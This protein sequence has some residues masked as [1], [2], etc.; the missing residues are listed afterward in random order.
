M[1]IIYSLILALG[2]I[3]LSYLFLAGIVSAQEPSPEIPEGYILIEGDILVPDPGDIGIQSVFTSTSLWPNGIVPY[4]FAANVTAISRT[5]IIS[6]MLEWQNAAN[7]NFRPRVTA[8]QFWVRIQN[9][10]GNNSPVGR[11]PLANQP[12]IINIFNWNSRFIMAHELAHTLGIWHE[13]SRPDRAPYVIINTANIISTQTHNFSIH[14][15]ADVYPLQVYGLSAVQ[16]YDF[17]S[18]MHYGQFDFSRNGK[19][20]ITIQPSIPN[21]T[22]LQSQIGQRTHLS[23]LDKLTMSF[24]YPQTNWRFVDKHHIGT[25]NGQFLTPYQQFPIGVTNTPSGG[26]LWLQPG[27][28]SA[29][30]T[31]TKPMTLQAPLSAVTLGN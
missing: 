19:P 11:Q 26:T 8:D 6:A 12:Q 5:N 23:K 31:Y 24:L 17:D 29:I 16:T 20:T 21:S 25:A 4:E 14:T 27:D 7:V 15:A 9:S 2:L 22:T 18:V 10:T 3:S 28:Y 13:Q 30:G 1:K